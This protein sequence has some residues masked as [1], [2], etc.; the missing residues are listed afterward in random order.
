[1][2]AKEQNSQGVKFGLRWWGKLRNFVS[3]AGLYRFLSREPK[4][5]VVK[6]IPA[7]RGHLDVFP[8][9]GLHAPVEK[10]RT[11]CQGYQLLGVCRL[12]GGLSAMDHESCV[13][14]SLAFFGS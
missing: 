13:C 11:L 7:F 12:R 5:V 8:E 4:V 1:M 3:K 2:S 6:M 10:N 14:A 9:N